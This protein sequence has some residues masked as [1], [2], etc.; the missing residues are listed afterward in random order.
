MHCVK[1]GLP[2]FRASCPLRLL[3]LREFLLFFF[4][5][6]CPQKKRM[7]LSE[8]LLFDSLPFSYSVVCDPMEHLD[9][10]PLHTLKYRHHR[11]E[12]LCAGCCWRHKL[13]QSS[14]FYGAKLLIGRMA[15]SAWLF[16]RVLSRP[17]PQ[18]EPNELSQGKESVFDH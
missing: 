10:A 6:Y 1:I 18:S 2:P 14:C 7:P 15:S 11:R 3:C 17:F 8:K 12:S 13:D 5:I 9:D 4:A 16:R